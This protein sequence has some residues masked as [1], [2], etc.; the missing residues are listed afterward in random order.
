MNPNHQAIWFKVAAWLTA[1][2]AKLTCR[3][4]RIGFDDP[5]GRCRIELTPR[6]RSTTNRQGPDQPGE[7]A[8]LRGQGQPHDAP[9][10]CKRLAKRFTALSA[11]ASQFAP[12]F[13]AGSV[14]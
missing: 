10:A 14:E 2:V 6:W 9:Q 11:Q 4:G 7:M 13:M 12:G 5:A 3:S 1:G 8:G